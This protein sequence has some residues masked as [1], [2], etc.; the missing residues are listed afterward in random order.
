M[1]S[2]IIYSTGSSACFRWDLVFCFLNSFVLF[3]LKNMYLLLSKNKCAGFF[4]S[5]QETLSDACHLALAMHS[6]GKLALA[7]INRNGDIK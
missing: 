7:A 5:L 6:S 2:S 3:F 4:S 1:K